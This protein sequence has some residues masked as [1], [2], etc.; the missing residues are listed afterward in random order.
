MT[1]D[2]NGLYIPEVKKVINLSTREARSIPT[3]TLTEINDMDYPTPEYLVEGLI[4]QCGMGVIAGNPKAGKSF[5]S[6]HLACC[7]AS[8]T[9]FLGREVKQGS[10]LYLALEDNRA[11]ISW[12]S[13]ATLELLGI[14][15]ALDCL[16]VHTQD[17]DRQVRLKDGG[18]SDIKHWI[19]NTENPRLILIDTLQVFK[20]TPKGQGDAYQLD[21]EMLSPIQE[22]SSKTG[23]T[24]GCIHH[25]NKNGGVMGSQG[26]LGSP[27][28]SMKLSKD[29]T[30]TNATLSG[31]GRDVEEF[32]LTLEKKK[33]S[34]E[35]KRGYIWNSLGET[36]IV[37][38]TQASHEVWS[39]GDLIEKEKALAKE[40]I[41][42]TIEELM[43]HIGTKNKE[44][45]KK[46]LYR[47]SKK[48]EL[49]S[50]GK[51]YWCNILHYDIRYTRPDDVLFT[52]MD[53]H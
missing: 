41:G 14:E 34:P 27:D 1:T 53:I 6:L 42:W 22:L 52:P 45:Y 39:S 31:K 30:E 3:K 10:V 40:P 15:S 25:M 37:N 2:I 36:H 26:I 11:R 50:K 24:I 13:K 49:E 38:G 28:W 23:I 7:V 32:S 12:R 9:P 48:G 19:E 8:G 21:V 35:D 18:L 4:P 44:K 46:R 33:V 51:Y 20:G 5:L 17:D 43:E 29:E 16:E 47:M